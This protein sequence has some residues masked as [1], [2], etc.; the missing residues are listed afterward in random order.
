MSAMPTLKT[1][2]LILRPFIL[3]DAKDVQRLAG[4]FF[5]AKTTLTIPHPYE[6]GMAEE[7]IGIHQ[8]DYEEGTQIIFAIV[9][10]E[11][12]QLLGAIGLSSIKQ[13]FEN[14][15]MGYWIGKEFWNKGYCT[16]AA[17][18]VLKYGF[19]ELGLNR[20]HA[21]HFGSNPVSGKIMQKIG[22]TYEGCMR[23]HIKKW[24]KFE[25]AVLYG[26]LKIEF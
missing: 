5:I 21:N 14:A 8:K 10:Q 6:D 17:R 7:W 23:Q 20:I 16:E 26:I 4:N 11:N 2:R 22:M 24:D 15:E 1:E 9:S 25:D 13:E 3:D 18:V 12:N 19:E